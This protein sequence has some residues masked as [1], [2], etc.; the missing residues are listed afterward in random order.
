M[1]LAPIRGAPLGAPNPPFPT[2]EPKEKSAQPTAPAITGGQPEALPKRQ[3]GAPVEIAC[4]GC[5]L[6]L[7]VIPELPAISRASMSLH[8]MTVGPSQSLGFLQMSAENARTFLTDL[9]NC[10]FPILATGDED[11]TMQIELEATE[12]GLAFCVYNKGEHCVL[13]RCAIDPSTDT[14]LMASELLADLGT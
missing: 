5:I 4:N 9:Q 11:G 6:T 3:R 14:K 10:R 13:R 1:T 8:I 7:R 12:T 2:E